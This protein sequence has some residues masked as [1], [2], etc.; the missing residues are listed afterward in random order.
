[1]SPYGVTRPQWIQS[2]PWWLYSME[3]FSASPTWHYRPSGCRS[4][5]GGWEVTIQVARCILGQLQWRHNERHGVSNHR[6]LDGLLN[7]LFRRRSNKTS[8]LCVTGLCE[9][10]SPVTGEFPSQR[11]SNAE[12]VSIWWRHHEYSRRCEEINC[13]IL[14]TSSL[15]HFNCYKTSWISS[16]FWSWRLISENVFKIF[17]SQWNLEKTYLPLQAV[18]SLLG[19]FN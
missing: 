18:P 15:W 5:C 6:R 14:Q 11:A 19:P 13:P 12:N 16:P 2:N 17:N 10:N 4:R 3:T 1:M 9:G 8:K 7:R